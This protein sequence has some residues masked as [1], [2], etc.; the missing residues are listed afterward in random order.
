MDCVLQERM[1]N[2]DVLEIR[3]VRKDAATAAKQADLVIVSVSGRME[4]PGSVRAWLDY[5]APAAR[6]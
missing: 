5:V 6:R 4:L 2:F 3:E 1:W